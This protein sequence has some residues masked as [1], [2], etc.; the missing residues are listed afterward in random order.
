MTVGA[1][2]HCEV[3]GELTGDLTTRYPV[4]L[5]RPI[6][7]TIELWGAFQRELAAQR[8]TIACEARGIGRS[9]PAATMMFRASTVGVGLGRGCGAGC[10]GCG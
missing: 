2:L 1:A 5:L 3:G 7:G 9:P 10:A 6:A 4:L 8:S